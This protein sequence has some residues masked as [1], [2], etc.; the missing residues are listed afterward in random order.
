MAQSFEQLLAAVNGRIAELPAFRRQP[1]R[2]YAPAVYTMDLGGKRIRPVMA[3][4]ASQLFGGAVQ[5]T[6]GPAVGLEVF[7]NFTLLHDDVMD[8]AA[9]RR[10]KPTVHAKWDTNTA[11]LT[12]DA[13]FAVAL[14]LM[15]GAPAGSLR[16][17]LQAF[18][19]LAV[20]VCEGQ[21]Y[22][23]NFETQPQVS[24]DEYME[25]I[26][27]KTAVLIAGALQI[28]A[29]AAGAPAGSVSRLQAYGT[30]IGL[31]F[32][33]QDDLLDLYADEAKFGKK[34]GSDIRENKKTYLYIKALELLPA[35]EAA[36]L[37]KAFA[38][39]TRPETEAGKVAFVKN[40]YEQADVKRHCEAEIQAM[41]QA[42]EA[43]LDAIP[44]TEIDPEAMT[45][46]KQFTARL[47][48]RD[49]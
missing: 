6:L 23:M 25:M 24:M 2:L 49:Y 18:G 34:I 14:Q 7:H 4:M 39:P 35:A 46:L 20:G 16:A 48:G 37:E 38:T 32:Q 27:L 30:Q 3:L 22:D 29:L 9:M 40:L 44:Q 15:S 8:R 33:L 47:L 31:A 43:H 28:G 21:Q 10:G 13:M 11:I 1:D 26:R 12:G 5:A 41:F 19:D 45:V 36:A 17:V 42:G